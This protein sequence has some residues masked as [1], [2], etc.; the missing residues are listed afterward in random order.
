MPAD[1]LDAEA[2]PELVGSLVERSVLKRRQGAG[3]DR[4][5]LLE[6]L[7]QFGRERLRDAGEET[8]FQLAPPRLDPGVSPRGRAE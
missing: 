1:G 4:F 6:P 2:I 7:R 3:G 8:R 5:R